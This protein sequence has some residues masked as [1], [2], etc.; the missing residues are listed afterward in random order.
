MPPTT[1]L[2]RMKSSSVR[3][4]KEPADAAISTAWSAEKACAGLVSMP[5]AMKRPILLQ[6]SSSEEFSRSQ[7][8]K[9]IVSSSRAF[10][11][12][13]GSLAPISAASESSSAVSLAISAAV[14]S[15]TGKVSPV[16]RV[17]CPSAPR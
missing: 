9:E 7:W 4:V 11:C 1:R 10:G 5:P 2:S 13:Q 12:A 3:L 15:L 6:A 14:V 17:R 16:Y 8:W